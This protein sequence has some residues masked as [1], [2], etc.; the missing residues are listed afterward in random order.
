MLVYKYIVFNIIIL[1]QLFN[2][3][4]NVNIFDK[5]SDISSKYRKEFKIGNNMLL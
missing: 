1:K 5:T 4:Q 2:H 3:G